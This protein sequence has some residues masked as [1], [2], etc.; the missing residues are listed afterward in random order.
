MN[1]L[2]GLQE[3]LINCKILKNC[4]L[5]QIEQGENLTECEESF[6]LY[7]DLQKSLEFSHIIE[8]VKTDLLQ[9]VTNVQ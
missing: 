8:F 6:N 4:L 2:K 5:F 9:F 1:Q 7:G 3:K